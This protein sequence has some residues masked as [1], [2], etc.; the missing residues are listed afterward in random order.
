M[1]RLACLGVVAENTDVKYSPYNPIIV[2]SVWADAAGALLQ[3]EPYFEY[4]LS[5]KQ[6]L[7]S[8]TEGEDRQDYYLSAYGLCCCKNLCQQLSLS[9]APWWG[10]FLWNNGALFP[11]GWSVRHAGYEDC[12]GG[13]VHQILGR[14]SWFVPPGWWHSGNC[15][16]SIEWELLLMAGVFCTAVVS[17]Y[18][19]TGPPLL[20]WPDL[21]SVQY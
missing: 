2:W 11:V 9:A 8:V 3:S 1:D 17:N 13:D 4:S 10:P 6:Y 12:C 15:F 20:Y 7:A 21:R 14:I 16:P 18:W 5:T 19:R